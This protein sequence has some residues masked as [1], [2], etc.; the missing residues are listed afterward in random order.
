MPLREPRCIRGSATCTHMHGRTK[1]WKRAHGL[2]TDTHPSSPPAPPA[3]LLCLSA[4]SLFRFLPFPLASAPVLTGLLPTAPDG[5]APAASGFAGEEV[6]CS[7]LCAPN[8]GSDGPLEVARETTIV[9]TAQV[10]RSR[11]STQRHAGQQLC[12]LF[13][14]EFRHSYH[15]NLYG[16][17]FLVIY[18]ENAFL[19]IHIC[20]RETLL[21]RLG[22]K[23]NRTVLNSCGNSIIRS[24]SPNTGRPSRPCAGAIRPTTANDAFDPALWETFVSTTLGLE[25]SLPPAFTRCVMGSP[26]P[27]RPPTPP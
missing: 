17:A 7:K 24:S 6:R 11:T 19:Y 4:A 20:E 8:S 9:S 3:A 18:T 25:I 15:C 27:C 21:N 5:D 16:N 26:H 22:S 2:C 23:L 14:V 12:S 10:Q 13:V 1:A